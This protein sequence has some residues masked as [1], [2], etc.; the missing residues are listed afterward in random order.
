VGKARVQAFIDQEKFLDLDTSDVRLSLRFEM[1]PCRPFGIATYDTVGEIRSV[2]VRAL[3][4]KEK[5]ELAEPMKED[6]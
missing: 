6:K 2:K 5:K 4:E 3:D 1:F